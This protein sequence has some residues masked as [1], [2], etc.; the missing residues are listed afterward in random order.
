MRLRR[1]VAVLL[2]CTIAAGCSVYPVAQDADGLALRRDANEVLMALQAWHRDRNGFPHSLAELVPAYLPALPDAPPLHYRS[3]DG[4]I[5]FRYIPT[6][7]QLR[8]VWCNSVGN[9]T[10]WVCAEH[11]LAS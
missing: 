3:S 2:A 8:P 1:S 7:P 10:N 4:S 6:W 9:T 5:S 11:L